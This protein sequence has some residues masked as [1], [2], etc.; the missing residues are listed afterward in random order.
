MNAIWQAPWASAFALESYYYDEPLAPGAPLFPYSKFHIAWIGYL[1]APLAKDLEL[2]PE[3][4]TE[5]TPDGGVLV[6]AIEERL[7]PGNAE[8]L[9]RARILAET[10]V[11]HTG[12]EFGPNPN[13]IIHKDPDTGRLYDPRTGKTVHYDRAG[14]LIY[15]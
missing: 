8:H 1:S 11:K 14:K 12:E 15:D 2:P 4:M 9:W 13:P 10:M 6:T 3:I 7:D 5:R